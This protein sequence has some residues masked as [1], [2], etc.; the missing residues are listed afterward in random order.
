MRRDQS[1][2]VVL[3][4]FGMSIATTF[5]AV[6]IY[7]KA[8]L[9]HLFGIDDVFLLL[10]WA[11]SMIVQIIIVWMKT[12]G[13][14]GMH[15]WDTSIQ[16]LKTIVRIT[17]VCSILYLAVMAFAKFSILIFHRRLSPQRWWRYAVDGT[18]ATIVAFTVSQM[19][20]LTFACISLNRV[21]DPTIT[22]GHCI[23]RGNVYMAT[24]GTNAATEIFMLFLPMPIL[25]KL[26]IPTIQ[27]VGLV[28]IFSVGSVTMATSLVRLSLMPPLIKNADMP[29]AL[30]TPSLWICIEG[31]L[32]IICGS[33]P[34]LR[35]FLKHT[36]PRLVGEYG[37]SGAGR[38]GGSKKP[39]SGSAEL[40][41]LERKQ[42]GRSKRYSRMT[43][44]TQGDTLVQHENGSETSIIEHKKGVS[45][46]AVELGH[47][48]ASTGKVD[49]MSTDLIEQARPARPYSQIY[50]SPRVSSSPPIR[51]PEVTGQPF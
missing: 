48:R 7:T 6:R 17:T 37:T 33:L 5:L 38:S 29:W 46:E 22:E 25:L 41:N 36:C 30:S 16:D 49:G 50:G 31:S 13:L 12:N 32:V 45:V 1:P 14:M 42:A 35:L 40:S 21:W 27:K 51:R 9:A 47:H 39:A 28:L 44:F 19:L 8:F 4:I 18:I 11:M 23:N 15:I 24:A 43:D 26:Q 3:A 20:L 10:S 2:G 34:V